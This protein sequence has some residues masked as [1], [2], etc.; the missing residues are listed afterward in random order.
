MARFLQK[1][2]SLD[3]SQF[4]WGMDKEV[5]PAN[6]SIMRQQRPCTSLN[7]N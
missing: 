5:S 1:F 6:R 3:V 2:K 7:S 4:T